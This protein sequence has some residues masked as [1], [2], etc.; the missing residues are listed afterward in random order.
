MGKFKKRFM[1]KVPKNKDTKEYEDKL[2]KTF[3]IPKHPE[4]KV[5]AKFPFKD[6][7]HSI[8]EERDLGPSESLNGKFGEP[9]YGV[10]GG[11][12][13]YDYGSSGNIYRLPGRTILYYRYMIRVCAEETNVGSSS[14]FEI[15]LETW[16]K[17][18]AIELFKYLKKIRKGS[19]PECCMYGG[20]K[21]WEWGLLIGRTGK[22]FMYD[23][24]WG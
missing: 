9:E 18:R 17:D 20:T 8:Y 14:S 23:S 22:P 3:N 1:Y 10:E 7:Y 11:F 19:I 24:G 12:Y 15:E 21:W 2:I 13:L 5:I 16:D 6:L 4:G